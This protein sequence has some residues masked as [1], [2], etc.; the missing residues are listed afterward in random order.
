MNDALPCQLLG[1]DAN[2]MNAYIEYVSDRLLVSLGYQK[3]YN[4]LNPFDFMNSIG[5]S[6]KNNFFE[7]RSTEY[8]SAA[9]LN[10]N[11]KIEITDDF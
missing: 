1:M 6:I 11:T 8:Q 10:E 5:L 7:S 9:V 3:V 2:K 4:T